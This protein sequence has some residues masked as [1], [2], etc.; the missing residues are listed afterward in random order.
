[1][2]IYIEDT[3]IDLP[4]PDLLEMIYEN[5]AYVRFLARKLDR[6]AAYRY[7]KSFLQE[8]DEVYGT[9]SSDHITEIYETLIAREASPNLSTFKRRLTKI[10]YEG[11][12]DRVRVKLSLV[13][14]G[15]ASIEFTPYTYRVRGGKPKDPVNLVFWN[16]GRYGNVLD[17][18]RKYL[19]PPWKFTKITNL[20][21]AET[22]YLYVNGEWV[23]MGA[24][25]SPQGCK[26]GQRLHARLFTG[27]Y[28]NVF[29]YVTVS[30]A[31]EEDFRLQNIFT[32]GTPHLVVGWDSAQHF[33]EKQFIAKKFTGTIRRQPLQPHG[34]ILQGVQHDGLA[35]LIEIL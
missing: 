22:Q 10:K 11:P 32:S 28:D 34:Q 9:S 27:G 30:A 13:Q 15:K 16:Q 3:E 33:V 26:F 29:G 6:E 7:V 8:F 2:F 23:K 17:I 1:M 24:S 14:V 35:S 25:L 12:R 18:M 4:L 5:A 20:T 31:H 21:C 19:Y